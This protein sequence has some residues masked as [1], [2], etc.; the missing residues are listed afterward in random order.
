MH[1]RVLIVDDHRM[2]REGLRSLLVQVPDI[3][4]VGEACSGSEAIQMVADFSPEVVLM[5]I[6]MPDMNG[7]EATR[8]LLGDNP[9]LRILALSMESEHRFIVEVLGA[10]ACG[11]VLKDTAFTEL[12][13]A[14]RRVHSGDTY[15]GPRISELIIKDYLLHIRGGLATTHNL[16]TPREQEMLQMI[17]DG[18][19]SKELSA[20]FDISIK[21]VEV[22]R[23]RIMKKLNL[24]SIAELTKYAVRE[25]LTSLG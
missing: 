10:G 16:L 21:T 11:Y 1:I 17:A 19:N 24:Y 23:H 2:F 25:G 5:D 14:I 18:K 3:E 4:V 12:A 6:A 9:A 22:H 7:I 15:L 8:Q 20:A 13:D